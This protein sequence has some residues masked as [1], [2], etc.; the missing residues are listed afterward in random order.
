MAVAFFTQTIN[1][2]SLGPNNKFSTGN[3]C[4][5]LPVSNNDQ[6]TGIPNSDLH[7]YVTWEDTPLKAYAARGG[8]CLL[9]NGPRFGRISF[10]TASPE[11]SNLS[12]TN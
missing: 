3:T 9:N 5:E 11:F 10:N 8:L 2:A 1:V 12:Y 7:I 4:L 6:V